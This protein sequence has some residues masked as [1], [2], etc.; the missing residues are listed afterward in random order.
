VSR[1]STNQALNWAESNHQSV[2]S[3]PEIF[4]KSANGIAN[5]WR[6]M[7]FAASRL[8][9]SLAAQSSAFDGLE[10]RRR[11]LIRD[12]NHH[13]GTPH[14]TKQNSKNPY[15]SGI[16]YSS[17]STGT[18]PMSA[19]QMMRVIE[20]YSGT[21][22]SEVSKWPAPPSPM[23]ESQAARPHGMAH[24]IKRRIQLRCLDADEYPA[25]IGRG[26]RARPGFV[27]WR[28]NSSASNW[29]LA[30]GLRV[31]HIGPTGDVAEWLKAAVC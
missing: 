28:G 10:K 31:G 2:R 4:L 26:P 11:G 8:A 24:V 21:W 27:K 14:R 15:F 5:S 16:K 22:L 7:P 12:R 6:Q 9:R 1:F 20:S 13:S 3:T 23:R 19:H 25:K 17:D 18:P 30:A 29:P